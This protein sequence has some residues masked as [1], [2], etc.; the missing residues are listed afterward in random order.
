MGN[1]DLGFVIKPRFGVA[2]ASYK[3]MREM[4]E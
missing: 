2:V 1:F 3:H 4:R